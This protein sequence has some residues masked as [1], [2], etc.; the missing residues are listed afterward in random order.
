VPGMELKTIQSFL[1][2][3][4]RYHPL[5]GLDSVAY[6]WAV[7]FS[8]ESSLVASNAVPRLVVGK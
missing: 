8:N 3:R 4:I 7:P 6:P 1:Q 2:S 5:L